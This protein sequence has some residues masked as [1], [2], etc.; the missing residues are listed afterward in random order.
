[1]T[2]VQMLPPNTSNPTSI[3]VSGR[4][5]SAFPQIPIPVQSADVPVLA[6][7]GWQTATVLKETWAA[8]LRRLR[9]QALNNNPIESPQL[10]GSVPWVTAVSATVTIT[11]ASP[12][13]VTWGGSG[14]F[15]GS[16]VVFSTT[17]AL[18]TGLTAGTIY[19]VVSAVGNIFSVAATPGGTAI[20]TTGTQ[21]GTQTASI[22]YA[23]GSVVSNAGNVYKTVA[24]GVAGSS[25]PTQ[26]TGS[27]SDGGITWTWQGV[28]TAP[29]VS[30]LYHTH[31]AAYTNSYG[32]TTANFVDNVA[33]FRWRGGVP[34]VRFG[35]DCA[36]RSVNNAPAAGD[37]G[38]TYGG[39]NASQTFVL[40]GTSCEVNIQDASLYRIAI[41][42]NGR[43]IDSTI[44]LANSGNSFFTIDFSNVKAF[45]GIDAAIGYQRNTITIDCNGAQD[46]KGVNCLPTGTLSYPHVTDNF[47]A[48]FIGDSQ[49]GGGGPSPTQQGNFPWQMMHLM[50]LPDVQNCSIGGTGFVSANTSTNYGG[51]AIADLQYQNS[52]RPIGLIF[53]QISAND[54]D[55]TGLL[56]IAG[57]GAASLAFFQALR[58]AFP[59][60]PIVA[61]GVITGG[62]V[63]LSVNQA[64]EAV[65]AANIETLQAAGDSM[66]FYVPA[67]LDPGGAWIT[68]TGNVGTPNGTGNADF[69]ISSDNLHMTEAGHSLYARKAM[70]GFFNQIVNIQ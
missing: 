42:V 25:A 20:N 3:T 24:G 23:P 44:Q 18:P 29:V 52:F 49:P 58:A 43:Y 19:Y 36:L 31:N 50:G 6:A 47:T 11:I 53:V 48:A 14:I 65:T 28:Q 60:V 21:S 56:P 15:T 61:T 2:T 12:G 51:H 8:R 4:T 64:I 67:A 33:P 30:A 63:A 27:A 40:E 70:T 35:G 46:F 32:I 59:T 22:A 26:V 66:L 55:I 9:G 45:T 41:I 69:D 17:G 5:Y 7:N 38:G 39:Q 10:I 68:G 37:L 1:M 16:A 54:H 57:L 34:Q 13:V 62:S